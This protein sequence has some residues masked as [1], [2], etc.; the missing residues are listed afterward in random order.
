MDIATEAIVCAALSHGEHGA[1]VRLLT[2]GHGLLSGYVRG[3]RSR[4]LRPV[5]Q[6]GN[7]VQA[8]LRS[9]VDEQL[10]AATVEL[11]ASRAGLAGTR[12]GAAA[13]GWLS[14]L[15]AQTLPEGMP[16]PQ[17]FSGLSSLLE[18]LE[19]DP[20]PWRATAEIARFELLLLAQLGFGLDLGSCAATGAT[21]GL[22]FVSP[23]SARA[24]S[25]VAGAPYA[26]KLLPLPRF[27]ADP[28]A[29]PAGWPDVLASLTT[30]GYFIERHLLGPGHRLLPARD[31]LLD[32]VRRTASAGASAAEPGERGPAARVEDV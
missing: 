1:V 7:L 17:V 15:V 21:S 20:S 18:H 11:V 14:A 32:A 4:K 25:A 28:S 12:I 6:P 2:P 5:I 8:H 22:S 23:K 31:R 3:G 24:V 30:T 27:L 13:L 10:A 26:G 9:R 29:E 16:Y 19:R